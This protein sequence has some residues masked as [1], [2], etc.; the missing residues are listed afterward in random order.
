MNRF[1]WR[2]AY[3]AMPEIILG[4]TIGVLAR[5]LLDQYELA[6][7]QQRNEQR[8]RRKR[9]EKVVSSVNHLSRLSQF[10][11]VTG[12]KTVNLSVFE[13]ECKAR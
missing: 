10:C 11:I 5:E 13:P 8:P 1:L 7:Q 2:M 6:H 9:V 3:E 4:T 12:T